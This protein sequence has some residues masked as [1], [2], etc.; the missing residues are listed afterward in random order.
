M[1]FKFTTD[2]N[3]VNKYGKKIGKGVWFDD[4]DG[5]GKFTNK[6]R[7]IQLGNRIR[8][9]NGD[10]VQLNSDGTMSR[11]YDAKSNA[12]E[13]W[14]KPKVTNNDIG[15][16]Q[17]KLVARKNTDGTHKW[18][19]DKDGRE[20]AN[21]EKYGKVQIHKNNN[22]FVDSN[23]KVMVSDTEGNL[24]DINSEEQMNELRSVLGINKP[25]AT[26]NKV[27][28][29]KI[30]QGLQNRGLKK[31]STN[32][33]P[34]LEI[35][36]ADIE[37]I[38]K[39]QYAAG[40][41]V[42]IDGSIEQA[43]AETTPYDAKSYEGLNDWYDNLDVIEAEIAKRPNA[44]LIYHP[45]VDRRGKT[46]YVSERYLRNNNYRISQPLKGEGENVESLGFNSFY[47]P[48]EDVEQTSLLQFSLPG[49][50]WGRND[51]TIDGQKYQLIGG[52]VYQIVE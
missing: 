12:V 51:H 3:Y 6:D 14:A 18:D 32:E 17:R 34:K 9:K 19:L 23:G 39:M 4:T 28:Q 8:N 41:P 35:R 48:V 37:T 31:V 22:A 46:K 38:A 52:K 40:L 10:Y 11:V 25:K 49:L 33:K 7:L 13:D 29:S 5:D 16:M 44:S 2:R 26:Q 43:L 42:D 20:E 1:A 15:A 30:L 36:D 27:P 50:L 24:V 45:F 47:R 21:N